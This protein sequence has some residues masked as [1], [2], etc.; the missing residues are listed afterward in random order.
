MGNKMNYKLA[1]YQTKKKNFELRSYEPGKFPSEDHVKIKVRWVGICGSD[2]HYL[3]TDFLDE[4]V[5]GHEWVGE[6]IECGKQVEN[7]SIGDLVTSAVQIKCG[8]CAPC[9]SAEGTCVNQ[10]Y[11]SS[12]KY[13]MLRQIAY[14][15]EFSLLKID[16]PSSPSTT[17]FEILAV[18]ENV[19]LKMKDQLDPSSKILVMGAGLL[20]LSVSLVLKREGFNIT[21]IETIPSRVLRAQS[22]EINAHHLAPAL[23]NA[24]LS[25]QF[26]FVFDCTGDHL[27][28]KGA[29]KYLDHFGRD[30]FTAVILAKYLAPI[31]FRTDRFFRKQAAFKWIQ[32]CT[33]ESLDAAIKNWSPT[34]EEL[35][36]TLIS[37]VINFEEFENAF[38]D[39]K[40][41]DK[42]ARVIIELPKL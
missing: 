13:G 18:A 42:A 33:K 36:K 22:L 20:G 38:K 26:D 37:H 12:E 30:R 7:L 5:L 11:L 29:I 9:I 40:D 19:Y 35:G 8:K 10:F 23:L 39:P 32:G 25:D 4:L 6:V 27:G 28:G 21:L 1:I 34:I 14:L 17:L 15:P 16:L 24:D 3:E 41:R 31:S 2:L